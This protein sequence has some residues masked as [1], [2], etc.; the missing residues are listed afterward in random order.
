[1][2]KQYKD[3]EFRNGSK[4]DRQ[5]RELR[6]ETKHRRPIEDWF[7]ADDEVELEIELGYGIEEDD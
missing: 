2:S 3:E 1:M 5:D 4:R 7:E 6:R